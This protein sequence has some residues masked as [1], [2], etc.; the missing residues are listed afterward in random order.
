MI[1][2]RWRHFIFGTDFIF[3]GWYRSYEMKY[4]I[5]AIKTCPNGK[6][7]VVLNGRITFLET[8]RMYDREQEATVATRYSHL[9]RIVSSSE[10]NGSH[11]TALCQQRR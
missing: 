2:W 11:S 10:Q 3:V 8:I 6:E 4:A 9:T 5:K 7:Y 1:P